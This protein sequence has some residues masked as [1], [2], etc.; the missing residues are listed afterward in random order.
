MF[1][2]SASGL[3]GQPSIFNLEKRYA[4]PISTVPISANINARVP[5]GWT[6]NPLGVN[7]PTGGIIGNGFSGGNV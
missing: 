6:T 5:W 1:F 4:V 3:P 7:A 2:V